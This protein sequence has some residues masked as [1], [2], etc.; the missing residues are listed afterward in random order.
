MSDAIASFFSAWGLTDADARAAALG[1]S[2]SP[3]IHYLDP[4]TPEP[5]TS[6]AALV[7]YVG[8]YTQYAPGATAAVVS[9]STTQG[10]HRAT[11]E[12]RMA[13][14]TVQLGQYFIEC[15]AEERPARLIGFVGLGE[16][17]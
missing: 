9:Q 12:F 14:G 8:M 13:D 4:R 11:V 10:H 15:D 6:L 7:D 17:E 3:D 1:Q 16:P 5:I 2:L